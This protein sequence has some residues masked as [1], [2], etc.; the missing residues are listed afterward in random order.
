L[1]GEG[2]NTEEVNGITGFEIGST[3]EW[4]LDKHCSNLARLPTFYKKEVRKN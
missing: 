3:E 4:V 1:T 2:R